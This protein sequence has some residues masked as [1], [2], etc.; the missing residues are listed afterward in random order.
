MSAYRAVLFLHF[1]TVVVLM[2][3]AIV[4]RVGVSQLR[5]ARRA[6]QVAAWMRSLGSLRFIFPVGVVLLYLTGGWLVGQAFRWTDGW[7]I[8][9]ALSLLAVHVNGSTASATAF[10]AIGMAM[11][12]LQDGPVPAAAHAPLRAERV[13]YA[14]HANLGIV[15]GV[16]WV[17]VTKPALLP[18]AGIVLAMTAVGLGVAWPTASPS[19]GRALR[20]TPEAR[21]D[22]A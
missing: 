12:G 4:S 1:I 9:S 13:W 21:A 8:V 19:P 16:I 5:R 7:V 20:P 6:E 11:R 17:M 3:A 22:E 15:L 10:R 2:S 14:V 18:S